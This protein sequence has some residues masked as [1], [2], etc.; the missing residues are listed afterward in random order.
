MTDSHRRAHLNSVPAGGQPE[1]RKIARSCKR[2][3]CPRDVPLPVGRSRPPVFCSAT[4]KRL[5]ARE[6]AEARATLLEAQR[7][8]S[9]YELDGKVGQRS[10]A[11]FED[12]TSLAVTQALGM[13]LLALDRIRAQLEADRPVT[14]WDVVHSIERAIRQA[15][16]LV[17]HQ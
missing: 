13:I 9:Q 3:S 2:P 11:S 1:R 5:Y 8:A 17:T 14:A 10:S 12:L 4:C 6:R 15:D 16:P 7:L